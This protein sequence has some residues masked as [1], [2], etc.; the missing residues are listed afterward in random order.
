MKLENYAQY[1]RRNKPEIIEKGGAMTNQITI[2][3]KTEL[4]VLGGHAAMAADYYEKATNNVEQEFL[5]RV[6]SSQGRAIEAFIEKVNDLSNQVFKV[7][8]RELRH[9]SNIVFRYINALESE[10]FTSNIIK[11]DTADIEAV[12]SWLKKTVEDV[13]GMGTALDKVISSI[14]ETMAHAPHP[15]EMG[16]YYKTTSVVSDASE[17]LEGLSKDRQT[18]NE[19]LLEAKR[20][21]EEELRSLYANLEALKGRLDNADGMIQID[22]GTFYSWLSSGLLTV[23]NMSM[24]DSLKVKGDDKMLEILLKESTGKYA[25][26]G[27][28]YKDL[29]KIDATHVSDGMMDLAYARFYAYAELGK[30]DKE[31]QAFF[32]SLENQDVEKA[33]IYLEKMVKSSDRYAAVLTGKGID[34]VPRL[35]KN[36]TKNWDN[37]MKS[38]KL[39]VLDAYLQKAGVLTSLFSSAYVREIGT[40]TIIRGEGEEWELSSRMANLKYDPKLRQFTW[41]NNKWEEPAYGSAPSPSQSEEITAQYHSTYEGVKNIELQGK[42]AE[43]DKKCSEAMKDFVIALTSQTAKVVVPEY[44]PIISLAIALENS[45]GK[46]SSHMGILDKGGKLAFGDKYSNISD[47]VSYKDSIVKSLET[48]VDLG[49]QQKLNQL[50]KESLMF[51]SG[52]YT[53]KS[54]ENTGKQSAIFTSNYDL[55]A[56]LA[57][58]DMEENGL[59]GYIYREASG[60]TDYVKDDSGQFILVKQGK[61]QVA[62]E[63]NVDEARIA[64]EAYD[65]YSITYR[66]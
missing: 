23:D 57:R 11:T 5:M 10:G 35:D 59:R 66:Q 29:G 47:K 52:G 25:N 37:L 14:L 30:N 26:P 50:E 40:S 2:L 43:L 3:S 38:G 32:D 60:V 27:D 63:A 6:S 48:Y 46:L 9:F 55:S 15:I 41:T 62:R 12:M 16:D 7:Y 31:I 61:I 21:F 1:Y 39:T 49:N 54:Y 24:L 8:P 20:H 56:S 33:G 53:T 45:D 22:V 65:T 34:L 42:A 17:T 51:N 18:K 4:S 64:V 13:E 19:N 28:F 36:Y 44:M 58:H